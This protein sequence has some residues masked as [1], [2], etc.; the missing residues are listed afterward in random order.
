M[1]SQF[2]N[3]FLRNAMRENSELMVI[4]KAKDIVKYTFAIAE[5]SPKKFR[6]TLVTRIH[7]TSLDVLENLIFANEVM[8]T[9]ELPDKIERCSYQRKALAELKVLDALAMTAREQQCILPKQYEN[10][11]RLIYECVKLLKAWQRSDERRMG[12]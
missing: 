11:S 12:I 8:L 2:S 10:L 9:G 5:N 7:N 6:F 1:F 4:T 3:G